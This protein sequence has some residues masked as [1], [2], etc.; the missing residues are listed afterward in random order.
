MREQRERSFWADVFKW[1]LIWNFLS[2]LFKGFVFICKAIIMAIGQLIYFI[3]IGIKKLIPIVKEKYKQFKI[4]YKLKYKPKI[5]NKISQVKGFFSKM[6][7]NFNNKINT[8]KSKSKDFSENRIKLREERKKNKSLKKKSKSYRES[9]FTLRL[10]KIKYSMIDFFYNY[11]F[12]III[13]GILVL[14]IAIAFFIS[15]VIMK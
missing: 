1:F 4:D 8:L 12:Q 13:I 9:D 7:S 10:K 11:E 6:K 15:N 3:S 2:L 5:D 14:G